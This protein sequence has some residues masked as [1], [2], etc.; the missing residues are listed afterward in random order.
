MTYKNRKGQTYYLHTHATGSGGVG[1]HFSLK[2]EGDLIEEIPDGY[3]IYE[4]PRGQVFLRRVV[5]Q[6]V[7]DEEVAV[8]RRALDRFERLRR[9]ISCCSM[10]RHAP[11]GRSGS[12][13]WAT[14]MT[15]SRSAIQ[16]RWTSWFAGTSSI[17]AETASSI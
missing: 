16:V 6:A 1:Y 5:P 9:C 7:S 14:L 12:A 4:S 11:L 17:W 13:I 2:P 8:V 10:R 15:G 3:E